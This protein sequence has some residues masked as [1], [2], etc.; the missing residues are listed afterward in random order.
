MHFAP[1]VRRE[2]LDGCEG[3]SPTWPDRREAPSRP[4][5]RATRPGIVRF[6]RWTARSAWLGYGRKERRSSGALYFLPSLR[7][8]EFHV[9][10]LLRELREAGRGRTCAVGPRRPG[11]RAQAGDG[12]LRGRDGL[13]GACG[14]VRRGE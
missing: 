9:R 4:S 8:P 14:A 2:D 1:A 6:V 11:A 5:T 10:D 3:A 12:A 13:D 7:L